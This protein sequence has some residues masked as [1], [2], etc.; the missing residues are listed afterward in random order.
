MFNGAFASALP[1]NAM[2]AITFEFGVEVSRED[3]QRALPISL[4]LAGYIFGPL[5]FGP[6]SEFIGRRYVMLIGF[7]GYTVFMLGCALSPNWVSLLM[8][9]L[10]GGVFACVPVNVGTGIIAD[11]YNEPMVRGRS[12]AYFM[13]GSVCAPLIAPSMSGYISQATTWRWTFWG[14]LILAGL[15]WIPLIFLPETYGPVLLVRRAKQLRKQA[16]ETGKANPKIFAPMELEHKSWQATVVAIFSR[17]FK[18]FF[19]ELIVL[20]T[21]LYQAITYAVFYMFFQTYP[22]IFN[23]IY[24][25][26]PGVMGLMYLPIGAGIIGGL[27][28]VRLWESF[29]ERARKSGKLWAFKEEYRRLPLVCLGGPLFVIAL[30]WLGWT[31]RE[32]IHWIVPCL[33]GIPFGV[34]NFA[35]TIALMNYLSD[36][37]GIHSASVM[38]AASCTRSILGAALPLV[39]G[40]MYRAL[41]VGWATSL[42]GFVGVVMCGV[43]FA[44]IY[45]GPAIRE[46]SKFCKSLA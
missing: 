34:G 43:P 27:I 11:I 17:P 32:D 2:S 10:L 1:S 21:C 39:S 25:M 29:L 30:F 38:A 42:I 31:A 35:G 22:V 14:G 20:T 45:Y 36:A 9:R 46:R 3:P 28:I 23:G 40:Q 8:F 7:A 26:E 16:L 13:A 19:T 37:Y 15:S 44:F 6:L 24:R 41:S 5:L 33:S 12:M 4:F 18:M